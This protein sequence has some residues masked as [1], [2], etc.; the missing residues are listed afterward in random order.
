MTSLGMSLGTLAYRAL[1]AAV[2]ERGTYEGIEHDRRANGQAA[3]VVVASSLAAGIGAAGSNPQPVVLLAVTALALVTW[4]SWAVIVLQI[5]GRYFAER[6]TQVDLGQLLRTTGFAASPGVLQVFAA[7]PEITLPVY[8][9]SW[10]W[11]LAAMTVAVR[12]ALDFRTMRRALTVCGVAFALV[13]AF[14]I[15][16]AMLVGPTAAHAQE[17]RLRELTVTA[18]GCSFTPNLLNV[19]RGDRVRLTFVAEDAPHAF[20]LPAYRIS[21]RATPDRAVTFAFLADDAGT[22]PFFSDLASDAECPDMHGELIVFEPR[23]HD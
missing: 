13:L 23:A 8:L 5:G 11:M 4:V 7:I 3:V 20:V 1:G 9:A 14:A 2:L 12:Q 10:L 21:K 16:L 19:E 18:R 17:R 15:T 22:F 6:E